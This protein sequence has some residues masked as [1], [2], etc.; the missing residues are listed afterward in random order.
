MFSL[1]WNN[2]GSDITRLSLPVTFNEPIN[3]LQRMCEELEYSELLDRACR[4]GDPADRVLNVAV[5]A[6]SGYSST[7]HRCEYKPYNPLL[8]ET[9]ECDRTLDC[10]FRFVAEKVVHHPPVCVCYVEGVAGYTY[11]EWV[12]INTKFGATSMD[13][14]PNGKTVLYIKRPNEGRD[15]EEKD[16]SESEAKENDAEQEDCYDGKRNEGK[17]NKEEEEKKNEVESETERERQ[18]GKVIEE[19][20]YEWNKVTTSIYNM[21]VPGSKIYMEHHGNMVVKDNTTGYQCRVI[22]HKGSF[23]SSSRHR[24]TGTVYDASGREVRSIS[25]CLTDGIYLRESPEVPLWRPNPMPDDYDSYFGLTQFAMELNELEYGLLD[26]LPPTDTRL[27]PDQRCLEEGKEEEAQVL[28]EALEETQREKR[29]Q[30][31]E[32]GEMYTP[33][34]FRRESERRESG[35]ER[36]ESE[37][38]ESGKERRESGKERRESESGEN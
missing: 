27:R 3:I 11:T 8:G 10:G 31:E 15:G 1:L 14:V 25:G 35:K 5:F 30:R 16:G 12:S 13:L 17:G 34:W 21:F 19:D 23:F 9:Y 38:R 29:K 37:R 28:K 20:Q 4:L 32:T 18:E 33:R 26:C 6:I 22:F 7:L 36:R 2:I 24:V